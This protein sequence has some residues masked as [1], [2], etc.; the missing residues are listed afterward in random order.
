[1]RRWWGGKWCTRFRKLHK[2]FQKLNIEPY[3]PA[4]PHLGIYLKELPESR[5]LKKHPHMYTRGSVIHRHQEGEA[6]HRRLR[7]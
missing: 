4:V 7:Q 2:G 5:D 3:N 6:G 1:M